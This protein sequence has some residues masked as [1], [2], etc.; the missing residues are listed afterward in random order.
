MRLRGNSPPFSGL[1]LGQPANCSAVGGGC[2]ACLDFGRA[3][4]AAGDGGG[5]CVWC[6]QE[7]GCVSAVACP[8]AAGTC[9]F[10]RT[11]RASLPLVMTPTTN[12]RLIC[13][14]FIDGV[15]VP[16][17]SVRRSPK[18]DPTTQQQQQRTLASLD[19]T[20]PSNPI[21]PTGPVNYVWIVCIWL[22][23]SALIC[24]CCITCTTRR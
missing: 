21:R 10:I 5:G 24:L 3:A 11:R 2:Q 18:K 22:V 16:R 7:G 17:D 15:R 4:A 23:L 6:P 9:T 12:W 20:T 8:T 1:G 13:F 14:D 19:S